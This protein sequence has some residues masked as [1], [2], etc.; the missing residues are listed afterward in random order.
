[1]HFNNFLHNVWAYC[2]I[3]K[4]FNDMTQ[5]SSSENQQLAACLRLTSD[6]YFETAYIMSCR[7]LLLLLMVTGK[8][9][10]MWKWPWTI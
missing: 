2:P 9:K 7:V 4:L 10:N 8:C 6:S 3:S 1:M 5:L